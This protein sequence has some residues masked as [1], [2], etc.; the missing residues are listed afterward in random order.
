MEDKDQDNWV[1]LGQVL[2]WKEKEILE[3]DLEVGWKGAADGN[4]QLERELG[5]LGEVVH[6]DSDQWTC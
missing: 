2:R 6:L 1:L 3:L 4:C 5:Q